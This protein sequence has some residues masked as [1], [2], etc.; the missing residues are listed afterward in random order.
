MAEQ[1]GTSAME[2]CVLPPNAAQRNP[3]RFRLQLV[4]GLLQ[5]VYVKFVHFEHGFP[6]AFCFLGIFVLHEFAEDGWDDLPR[7]SELVFQPTAAAFFSA[8][9]EL[10]PERPILW[11][12][13]VR[14]GVR[15]IARWRPRSGTH[16]ERHKPA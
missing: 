13:K 2:E 8:F 15:A 10:L 3:A 1:A 7:E 11:R 14:R 9:G 4:V 16:G 12:C 6:D 5:S